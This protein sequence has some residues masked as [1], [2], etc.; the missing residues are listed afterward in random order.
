MQL[1]R[2]SRKHT[3]LSFCGREPTAEVQQRSDYEPRQAALLH[4]TNLC[5]RRT[6]TDAREGRRT[7]EDL[8][9]W[10]NEGYRGTSEIF[11]Y[12][13]QLSVDYHDWN[14]FPYFLNPRRAT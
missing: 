7:S 12:K 5:H 8:G 10:K 3:L 4:R 2:L 6:V 13:N 9:Y 14:S 11:G 1:P